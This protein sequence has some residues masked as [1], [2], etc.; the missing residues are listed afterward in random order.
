MEGGLSRTDITFF[1][2]LHLYELE[3]QANIITFMDDFSKFP[4]R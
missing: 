4:L 1:I 2:M 3:V